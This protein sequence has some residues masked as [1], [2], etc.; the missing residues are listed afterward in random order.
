MG[1]IHQQK[2]YFELIIKAA[3]ESAKHVNLCFSSKK[4]K[5][6]D[7]Q[8][9]LE[10]TVLLDSYD[11][12]IPETRWDGSRDWS[13]TNNGLSEG[14]WD[15]RDRGIALF[16]KS[17]IELEESLKKSPEQVK[18]WWV[19]IPDRSDKGSL[20]AFNRI[21]RVEPE[22]ELLRQQARDRMGGSKHPAPLRFRVNPKTRKS[23]VVY[24]DKIFR[25]LKQGNQ[26]QEKKTWTQTE[27]GEV[28]VLYS[29]FYGKF[30]PVQRKLQ[31]VMAN[32]QVFCFSTGPF[33][34]PVQIHLDGVLPLLYVG[35][36]IV[37]GVSGKLAESA[38][39]PT[40]DVT[41]QDVK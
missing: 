24:L 30:G 37:L 15:E 33:L 27:P 3:E 14:T 20:L 40:V 2:L 18:S 13:V 22:K 35:C 16:I 21:Q 10:A 6:E 23:Y 31:Y 12:V 8:E 19:T 5:L 28:Q 29:S 39:N 26:R 34:K 17:W 36:T 41:D 7:K 32:S 9:E 38:S 11:L 4:I 25:T 1:N